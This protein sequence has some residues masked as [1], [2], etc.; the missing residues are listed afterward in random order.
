MYTCK[1]ACCMNTHVIAHIISNFPCLSQFGQTGG[2]GP[3]FQSGIQ[4]CSMILQ[5]ADEITM[6]LTVLP[7]PAFSR[8]S[9]SKAAGSALANTERRKTHKEGLQQS[10]NV[11]KCLCVRIIL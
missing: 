1:K 5:T 9:T 3:L 2:L 7:L 11:D 4:L 6:Q 8:K 10:T